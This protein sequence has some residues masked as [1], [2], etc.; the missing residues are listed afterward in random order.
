MPAFDSFLYFWIIN[1]EGFLL[2]FL[3]VSIDT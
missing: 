2:F 1:P 3:L